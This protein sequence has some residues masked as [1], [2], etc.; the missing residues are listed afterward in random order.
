MKIRPV[1]AEL[2]RADGQTDGET[3]RYDETN[4]RLPQFSERAHKLP[5]TGTHDYHISVHTTLY[6]LHLTTLKYLS[7][8][9]ANTVVLEHA[10]TH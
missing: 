4:S 8:S 7:M 1:R 10:Q 9:A 6:I 2:L 3:D 5:I